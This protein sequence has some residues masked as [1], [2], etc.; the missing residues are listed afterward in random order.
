MNARPDLPRLLHAFFC[1]WAIQQ[2]NLSPHTIRSYRD[3]WRL[4]LRFATEHHGR[5]VDRLGIEDLDK[6]VVIAF[7]DHGER[8]RHGS[9]GTRNCRL[10]AIRAFFAFSAA[11][12]PAIIAL[13]GGV[14]HVPK[15]R[16]ALPALCYLDAAEV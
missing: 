15:K 6:S 1:D 14:L 8:E 4:F 12:E 16:A 5:R 7:L 10:A 13:C 9:I 11:R 3:T 2:R